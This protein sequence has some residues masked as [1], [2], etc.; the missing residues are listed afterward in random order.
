[1]ITVG[2]ALMSISVGILAFG[3][4]IKLLQKIFGDKLEEAGKI[5]GAILLGLGLAFSAIGLASPLILLGSA[6]VGLMG[7]SLAIISVGMLIFAGASKLF[8][9][10]FGG[11]I[12]DVKENVSNLF[13]SMISSFSSAGF[14]ILSI[15]LGSISLGLMGASML[16]FGFSLLVTATAMS[17]I[18]KVSDF[19]DNV[20]GDKG[21]IMSV[22]E[23]F[24]KIGKKYSTGLISSWLGSD[25]VSM[26]IRSVRGMGSVLSELAGGIASF[27]NFS[28]FPVKNPNPKNPSKLMY[29]TVDIF[30]D[31]IP[32]LNTNLPILLS[33]LSVSF[34]EIGSKYGGG[35]GWFSP[36]SPVQKGI[37]AIKGLGTVLS[38]LAGGIVSFANFEAFPVQI[39]DEKDSSKLVY[40]SVNLFDIIPKIKK[41]LIGDGT[42][43]GKAN[44]KSGILFS[45]ANIFGEIGQAYPDGFFSDSKVKQGVEATQGIGKVIS[46]LANG[47]TAFAD[48]ERGLP[49]L[50]KDGKPTGK[51][52]PVDIGKIQKTIKKILMTIPE[53][54]ASFDSDKFDNK[55]I[56]QLDRVADILQKFSK[57]GNGL[58]SFAESLT[59]TA[60]AFEAFGSGFVKFSTNMD[61]FERF[62]G[63]FGRLVK[64]QHDYKFNEFSK[65]MVSLKE[66]VNDFDVKKLGLTDSLMSSLAVISKAPD[67]LGKKISESLDKSFDELVKIIK[68]ISSKQNNQ[69]QLPVSPVSF[70]YQQPINNITQNNQKTQAMQ[71]DLDELKAAIIDLSGKFDTL[72]Q[73]FKIGKTGGIMVDNGSR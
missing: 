50:D 25:P 26:G 34:S 61:K 58:N 56:K 10:A 3:I 13:E 19:I 60:L 21:I 29:G 18:P 66:S 22:S 57:Y 30:G 17:K 72:N 67:D 52:T 12:K 65:S 7:A 64:K 1:M 45:L 49:V 37:D 44:A 47:I 5:S 62:E 71:L 54:F 32:S 39:I 73:K 69:N 6:S 31:I 53:V 68:E 46:E 40:K 43:S 23:A 35:D 55:K 70:A 20:F 48:L 4:S 38:E 28:E 27:A 24:S 8:I 41:V 15:T 59:K 42:L 2:F 33:A 16:L 14:S 63:V 9:N 51:F 11:N 36:K